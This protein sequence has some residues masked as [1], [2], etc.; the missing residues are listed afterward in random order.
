MP[1]FEASFHTD[2]FD[3]SSASTVAKLDVMKC[4]NVEIAQ[5]MHYHPCH[6]AVAI[7]AALGSTAA[8]L[9]CCDAREASSMSVTVTFSSSTF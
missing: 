4:F 5:L 3:E 9:S 6:P 8:L 1:D 7:G 2:A